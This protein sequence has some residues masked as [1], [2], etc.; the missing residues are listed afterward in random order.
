MDSLSS[1]ANSL[2]E[3]MAVTGT[4][5]PDFLINDDNRTD[6]RRR[7]EL[8]AGLF[9]LAS[10]QRSGLSADGLQ[11]S[12]LYESLDEALQLEHNGI[13]SFKEL[14]DFLDD[15]Q[16]AAVNPPF[17]V[18]GLPTIEHPGGEPAA[19]TYGINLTDFDGN[20]SGRKTRIWIDLLSDTMALARKRYPWREGTSRADHAEPFTPGRPP[21]EPTL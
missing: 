6:Q 19:V 4:V 21:E 18:P 10:A 12:D 17:P 15:A 3:A 8:I 5:L 13:Y 16:N 7:L 20:L 1:T 9:G 2:Y 11:P 14:M